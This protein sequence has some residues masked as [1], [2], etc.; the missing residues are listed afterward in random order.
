MA[1]I[2][3]TIQAGAQTAGRVK[4]LASADLTRFLAAY[5]TWL[6]PLLVGNPPLARA[7]TD[8]EV[9][10]AWAD[11]VLQQT[12]GVIKQVEAAALT[13]PDVPLT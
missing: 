5:R 6:P 11:L 3:V 8:Q 10:E 4:T 2:T 9:I 13:V 1:T 12:V 7:R